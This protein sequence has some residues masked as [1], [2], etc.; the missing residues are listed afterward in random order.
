MVLSVLVLVVIY[1]HA[2]PTY[3]SAYVPSRGGVPS[4]AVHCSFPR[5]IVL[6]VVYHVNMDNRCQTTTSSASC[7]NTTLTRYMMIIQYVWWEKCTMMSLSHHTDM[8]TNSPN[9]F[10]LG[11][12]RITLSTRLELVLG[13]CRYPSNAEKAG[14]LGLVFCRCA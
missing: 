3:R 6:V 10:H 1:N 5:R 14:K 13:E 4:T 2:M 9:N 11:V 7:R 12:Y 8:F